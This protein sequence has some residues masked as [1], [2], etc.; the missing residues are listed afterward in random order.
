MRLAP[1]QHIESVRHVRG[2]VIRLR[3]E[4]GVEGDVDL[5]DVIG[6]FTG[7]LAPL[8]DPD[9]VARVFVNEQRTITW[10]GELD[11][12]PVVLYCAVRGVPVPSFAERARAP[13]SSPEGKQGRSVARPPKGTR[14][15]SA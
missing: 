13:K 7:A 14:K 3:F 12:D 4:D 8:A 11:L 6:E 5:R 9:F 10:P 1:I 2:H 15:S